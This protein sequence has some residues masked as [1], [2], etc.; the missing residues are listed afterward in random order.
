DIDSDSDKENAD[1]GVAADDPFAVDPEERA[2]AER[3]LK[4]QERLQERH[5]KKLLASS[6]ANQSASTLTSD[7]LDLDALNA[8]LNA[9]NT[10]RQLSFGDDVPSC[11]SWEAL[12]AAME[13]KVPDSRADRDQKQVQQ[14]EERDWSGRFSVSTFGSGSTRSTFYRGSPSPTRTPAA[15]PKGPVGKLRF[16]NDSSD[17][18]AEEPSPASAVSY[19]TANEPISSY[20][21][22]ASASEFSQHGGPR[23]RLRF[24]AY[25]SSTGPGS[26]SLESDDYVL[27]NDS[28][29]RRS[30]NAG[31]FDLLGSISQKMRKMGVRQA[32]SNASVADSAADGHNERHSTNESLPQKALSKTNESSSV[33]PLFEVIRG[34][35]RG[36]TFTNAQLGKGNFGAVNVAFR[37]Y[38]VKQVNGKDPEAVHQ[39][40]EGVALLRRVNHE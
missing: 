31:S 15:A 2:E 34:E 37:D 16:D 1:P 33:K 13:D 19:K 23:S 3:F 21:T 9:R 26:S 20:E 14:F 22:V 32:L 6:V 40:T 27:V 17:G 5:Q 29:K 36:Y 4:E 18:E 38:A 24:G 10:T 30:T 11:K 12:S 39:C 25:T 8:R 28:R 35:P 7:S